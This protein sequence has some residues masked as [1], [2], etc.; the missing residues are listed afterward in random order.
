[1]TPK[2]QAKKLL[3]RYFDLFSIQLENTISEY[4][5]KHCALVAV[6]EIIDQWDYIDTYIADLKGTLNPNL[7][8]W[9]EVKIELEKL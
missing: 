2:E 1:M 8:Y 3:N 7:K 5:A 6:N 9:I 4:E